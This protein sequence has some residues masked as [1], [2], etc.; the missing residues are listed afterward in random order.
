[1]ASTLE[2]ALRLVKPGEMVVSL[3]DI[4][5]KLGDKI[6]PAE[7]EQLLIAM[8]SPRREKVQPGDLISSDVL[9]Q[10]LVELSDLQVR[11]LNLESV[12]TGSLKPTIISIS[13]MPVAVHGTLTVSGFNFPPDPDLAKVDIAGTLIK[14]FS[15]ATDK[16]LV[17][18]VPTLS[19][20]LPADLSLTI[21]NGELSDTDTVRVLP[22]QIQVSGQ[23]TVQNKT[24]SLPTIVVGQNYNV[25]FEIDSITNIAESYGIKAI[26]TELVGTATET[27]WMNNTALLDPT[28]PGTVSVSEL[29]VSPGIP[30]RVRVNF[31]VPNGATSAKLQLKASSVSRPSDINLNKASNPPLELKVGQV[32][33]PS[34]PNTN[35]IIK[36]YGPTVQNARI[37][38]INGRDGVEIKFGETQFV[39]VNATFMLKGTYDYS[40]EVSPDSTGWTIPSTSLTPANSIEQ[41]G[42]GETIGMSVASI[43]T[44]TLPRTL[45]IKAVRRADAD[46]PS[47]TSWIEIPIRG[48]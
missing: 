36:A 44:S 27:D 3:T 35:F 8:L 30:R 28:P 19:L 20:S 17:F 29:F 42:G 2:N 24:Q 38:Q 26:F 48:Y 43:D 33:T 14:S 16:L 15:T 9:N 45:K 41:A 46:G 40:H 13:P 1:M 10:I 12:P 34:D 7:K 23:V 5:N 11:V 18:S 31:K 37:V 22:E 32:V 21:R 6:T 4:L 39:R 47:I 25:D